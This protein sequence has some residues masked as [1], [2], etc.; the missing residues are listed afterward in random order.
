M[1]EFLKDNDKLI[2]RLNIMSGMLQMG[3]RIAFGSDAALLSEAA[4]ALR[5]LQ[6]RNRALHSS[7]DAWEQKAE[8]TLATGRETAWQDISTAPKDGTYV[9]LYS[10]SHTYTG[11]WREGSRYEPQPW[12]LAWR[13]GSGKFNTVTHWQ[14][15]PPPPSALVEGGEHP[16]HKAW[17]EG[18]IKE[19]PVVMAGLAEA[20]PVP[21]SIRRGHEY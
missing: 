9:L 11:S 3:E 5:E 8:A 4:T 1:V 7:I 6:E 21:L 13:D 12:E 20:A 16:D 10:K 14:P 17:A 2:E 19:H 18:F 15:L